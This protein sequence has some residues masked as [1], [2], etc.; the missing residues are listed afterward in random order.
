MTR[1]TFDRLFDLSCLVIGLPPLAFLIADTETRDSTLL[2]VGMCAG[3]LWA[4][5]R[6][7]MSEVSE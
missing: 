5:W 7:D 2:M 4:A 3:L 6:H 1:K